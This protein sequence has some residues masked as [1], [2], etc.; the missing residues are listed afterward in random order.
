MTTWCP[1]LT[2]GEIWEKGLEKSFFGGCCLWVVIA[3]VPSCIVYIGTGGKVWLNFWC[4]CYPCCWTTPLRERRGIEGNYFN[5]CC[6]AYWCW[7]C[8]MIREVREAKLDHEQR[9]TGVPGVPGAYY[10]NVP[11]KT[12]MI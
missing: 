1:C 7:C 11:V 3:Y 8:Q 4:F 12:A 10:S 6:C 2:A 9:R 5:D